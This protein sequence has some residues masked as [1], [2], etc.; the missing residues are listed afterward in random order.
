MRKKFKLVRWKTD[1]VKYIEKR[2]NSKYCCICGSQLCDL[3]ERDEVDIV[4]VFKP[5]F[6]NIK[7][8][9]KGKVEFSTKYQC[10]HHWNN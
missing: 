2:Y 7:A 6:D 9:R 10:K 4:E 8:W 3:W 1:G 5:N